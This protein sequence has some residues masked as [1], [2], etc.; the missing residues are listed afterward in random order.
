MCANEETVEA[1]HMEVRERVDWA[2][3][4]LLGSDDSSDRVR[5]RSRSG[6]E[7]AGLCTDEYLRTLVTMVVKGRSCTFRPVSAFSS[8]DLQVKHFCEDFA[9]D[10][11]SLFVCL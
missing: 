5:R 7:T 10:R 6:D 4:L 8:F 11:A 3:V 9:C 2:Y 1:E